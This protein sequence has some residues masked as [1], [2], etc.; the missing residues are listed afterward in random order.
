MGYTDGKTEAD[1]LI[2]ECDLDE[3]Y[4]Q[5]QVMKVCTTFSCVANINHPSFLPFSTLSLSPSPLD[6]SP[7]ARR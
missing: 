6:P 1:L 2:E 4:G 3:D 5:I 7:A